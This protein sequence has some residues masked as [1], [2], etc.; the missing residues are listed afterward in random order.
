MIRKWLKPLKY[1]VRLNRLGK[2]D[3]YN[4]WPRSST[5]TIVAE[6]VL[7]KHKVASKESTTDYFPMAPD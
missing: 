7:H 3:V 6:R 4:L 2:V 5:G 1:P